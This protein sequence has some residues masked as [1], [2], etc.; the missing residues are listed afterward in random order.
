[1]AGPSAFGFNAEVGAAMGANKTAL[2]AAMQDAL[3]AGGDNVAAANQAVLD[4][5]TMNAIIAGFRTDGKEQD[6]V[7]KN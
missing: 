4:A 1:M 3:T 5:Q 7:I 6:Q 2:S